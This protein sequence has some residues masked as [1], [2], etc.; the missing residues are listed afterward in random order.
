[1]AVS[2]VGVS[3]LLV[4]QQ[5][6][7][8]RVIGRFT[9]HLLPR[10]RAIIVSV[11]RSGAASFQIIQ[12][13]AALLQILGWSAVSW[14]SAV[15]TNYLL[16]RALDL[17]VPPIAALL[18]LIVLHVGISLPSLPASVGIFEYLCILSLGLFGVEQNVGLSF[19]IL[20]HVFILVP[21]VIGAFLFWFS[22]LSLGQLRH[23]AMN[24]ES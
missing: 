10:W 15:L 21:T 22:G 11:S 18:V 1:M 12:Q 3:L 4:N 7:L 2:V 9:S 13:P 23:S 19:G 5:R 17:T 24:G 6:G 16:F 20:L 14:G 8:I